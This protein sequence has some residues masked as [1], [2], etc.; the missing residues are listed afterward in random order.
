MA[1]DKTT[2]LTPILATPVDTTPIAITVA[3]AISCVDTLTPP[4]A[5][6][7]V[8]V[9]VVVAVVITAKEKAITPPDAAAPIITPTVEAAIQAVRATIGRPAREDAQNDESAGHITLF[10]TPG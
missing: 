3:A 7:A 9:A 4:T 8:L 6:V 2:G 5:V 10:T 1:F